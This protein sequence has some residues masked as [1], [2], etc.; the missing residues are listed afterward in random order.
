MVRAAPPALGIGAASFRS[1]A[2]K[3]T[4]ESPTATAGTLKKSS[5]D[6]PETFYDVHQSPRIGTNLFLFSTNLHGSF[7]AS[8]DLMYL[9]GDFLASTD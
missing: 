6:P 1:A 9:H 8:T 2:E 5:A 3:D 7:L 4:A